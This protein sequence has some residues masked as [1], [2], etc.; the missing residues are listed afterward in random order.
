MSP[1]LVWIT[2]TN[3]ASV[4]RSLASSAAKSNQGLAGS[5]P[6]NKDDQVSYYNLLAEKAI[7]YM[8]C[9]VKMNSDAKIF[10]DQRV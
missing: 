5:S 3:S 8:Y 7:V 9:I 2:S 10:A 4:L 6:V 1:L